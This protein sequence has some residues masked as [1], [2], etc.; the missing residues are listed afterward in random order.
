MEQENQKGN[1][2]I[3]FEKS[4]EWVGKM[5]KLDLVAQDETGHTL[6]C[7]CF[8]EE[9]LLPYAKYAEWVECIRAARLAVDEFYLFAREGFDEQVEALARENEKVHTVAWTNLYL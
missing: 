8:G 5:G 3:P 9:A 7:G 6:V 2:P 4:G 1:L